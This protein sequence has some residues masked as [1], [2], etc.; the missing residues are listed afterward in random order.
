MV[1]RSL[2]G[3]GGKGWVRVGAGWDRALCSQSEVAGLP[4]TKPKP[5][6]LSVPTT[7]PVH[8]PGR[9]LKR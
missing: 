8:A 7:M 4:G 3:F 5:Q 9:V 6:A 1:G 2:Q